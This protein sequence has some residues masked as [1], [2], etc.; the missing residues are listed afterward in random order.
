[1]AKETTAFKT[2]M[3]VLRGG[4]V[5]AYTL[6]YLTPGRKKQTGEFETIL[7]P[8]AE[9]GRAA[10]CNIQYGDNYPTV[11]R[12]HAAI[13]RRGNNY[14]LIHLSRKNPT[15]LN[16][17][18]VDTESQLKN[19]D[20]IQ[21]SMEG[22]KLRFNIT[23]TGSANMGFTRKIGLV[24]KQAIKPYRT[25]VFSLL[26]VILAIGGVGGWF[27]YHQSKII[28]SLENNLKNAE[29]LRI[30]D[31]ITRAQEFSKQAESTARRL[32]SLMSSNAKNISVINELNKKIEELKPREI[33][34]Q[35]SG[36][37][38]YEKYRDNIY[39][40]EVVEILVSMPDGSAQKANMRWTG[41][42]FLCS[43]GKLVTARHCIQGWRFARDEISQVLNFAELNGGKLFVKFRATS[44]NNWFEFDYSNVR[45]DDS[46]DETITKT[47]EIVAGRKKSKNNIYF[48]YANDWSTDWAFCQTEKTSNI[49]YDSGLSSNLKAGEKVYL[50]GFSLGKGGPAEGKI[51]P[52]FSESNIGQ[53]GISATGLITITSRSFEQG[54]SGGPAFVQSGD[55]FKV[56]GIVSRGEFDATGS[57][58]TIAYI[59]PIANVK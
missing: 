40:L 43:D 39:F 36:T 59:V 20:E 18:V 16:G 49:S 35:P 48:K 13:E 6:E 42:A 45:F 55:D 58:A 31:S 51:N 8:Y 56:V 12:K 23:P 24:T 44:A 34:I 38:F 37:K 17:A 19:G 50:L 1:M 25:L 33:I 15:L 46:K 11:S 53:D 14:F 57:F 41:T 10:N 29:Q 3:T 54:N 30:Q 9:I 21:F 52:L 47:I 2:G 5:P 32:E 28:T 22:P 27:I 4:N 26:F 7:V